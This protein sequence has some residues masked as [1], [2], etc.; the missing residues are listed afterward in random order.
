MHVSLIGHHRQLT[1]IYL[2]VQDLRQ[3]FQ[4][5]HAHLRL[6]PINDV[7]QVSC[8]G[9][10]H[11]QRVNIGFVGLFLKGTCQVLFCHFL[12]QRLINFASV[13]LNRQEITLV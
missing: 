11:Q 9:L 12:V 10:L 3:L 8:V 13:R 4:R 6:Q 1:L 2:V 7:L 5:C